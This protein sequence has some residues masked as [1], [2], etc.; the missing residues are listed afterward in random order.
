MEQFVIRNSKGRLI[1]GL[2]MPLKNIAQ[3]ERVLAQWQ[4]NYPQEKFHIEAY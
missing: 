1:A 3:A 2:F 4:Y